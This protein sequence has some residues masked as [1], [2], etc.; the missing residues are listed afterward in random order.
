MGKPNLRAGIKPEPEP[1]DDLKTFHSKTLNNC[2]NHFNKIANF[3]DAEKRK[4]YLT[5]LNSEII[6]HF[7]TVSAL[8]E[9]NIVNVFHRAKDVY[10]EWMDLRS[11]GIIKKFIFVKLSI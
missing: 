4:S 5:S 11:V 8:N 10:G 6:K 2:I 1:A 3:G 7:Q 9:A